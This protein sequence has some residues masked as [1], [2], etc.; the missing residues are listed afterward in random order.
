MGIKEVFRITRVPDT[1]IEK[2]RIEWEIE[3]RCGQIRNALLRECSVMTPYAD[4]IYVRHG[5]TITSK[6]P[7]YAIIIGDVYVLVVEEV[8]DYHF[9]KAIM[10]AALQLRGQLQ[11]PAVA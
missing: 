3:L 9:E 4:M 7:V 5:E 1:D 2:N 8:L 6:T 11:T 10:E